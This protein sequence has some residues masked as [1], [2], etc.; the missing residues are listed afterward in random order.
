MVKS[1]L[2]KYRSEIVSIAFFGVVGAF[3]AFAQSTPK[4]NIIDL[5]S[6]EKSEIISKKIPKSKTLPEELHKHS[7]GIGI[8]QTF[9]NSELGQNGDDH[10]TLD[11]Y[12]NYRASHSFDLLVNLHRSSHD[13]M[14]R[15]TSVT[16]LAIGIKGRLFQ[17][18]SFSPFVLGGLGF[19]VPTVTR[20]KNGNLFSTPTSLAFGNHFG[21][22]GELKLN[23]KFKIAALMHIHNPFDIKQDMDKE[24]ESSY[25]K[26]LLNTYYTF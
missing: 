1:Y 12:Y 15:E 20:Y 26:L 7:L 14:P 10:I 3:S 8:G 2:K 19:Y 6:K 16:G 9:L 22:G 11:L 5:T 21:G 13:R 18:D 4:P 17:F 23:N 24:L 25:Y